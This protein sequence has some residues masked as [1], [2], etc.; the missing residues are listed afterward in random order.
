MGERKTVPNC[1]AVVEP[2]R[3]GVSATAFWSGA[4]QLMPM[5]GACTA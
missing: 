3:M 2:V 4:A 1:T 5:A